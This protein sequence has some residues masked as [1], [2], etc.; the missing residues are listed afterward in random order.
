[1]L[2]L[3]LKVSFLSIFMIVAGCQQQETAKQKYLPGCCNYVSASF[4]INDVNITRLERVSVRDFS[5]TSLYDKNDDFMFSIYEGEHPKIDD[6]Y[7]IK[8]DSDDS[9]SLEKSKAG[10]QEIL[11]RILDGNYPMFLHFQNFSNKYEYSIDPKS[12]KRWIYFRT[13][14]EFQQSPKCSYD[15]SV[16]K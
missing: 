15:L 5:V 8:T 3:V 2:N 14:P 9:L 10:E 13:E 1:M 16:Y 12:T 4:C 7:F 11:I 6:K